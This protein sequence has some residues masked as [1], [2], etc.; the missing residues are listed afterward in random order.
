MT[1]YS[2]DPEN[3]TKSCKARGSNL[4][5]H[6]KNTHETAVAIKGM[7]IRKANKYLKDVVAKKQIIPFLRF[8]GGVGR[9]AQVCSIC[10]FIQETSN[11]KGKTYF[12]NL[13]WP[14]FFFSCLTSWIGSVGRSVGQMEK[15][16]ISARKLGLGGLVPQH[17]S[18]PGNNKHGHKINVAEIAMVIVIDGERWKRKKKGWPLGS[19]IL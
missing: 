4:R 6:F 17:S 7:H 8:N 9:K 2:T 14:S 18:E 1:R 3:P 13:L 12:F 15:K 19:A 10:M 16:K 5:V 11:K